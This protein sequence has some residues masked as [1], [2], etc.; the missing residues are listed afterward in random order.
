LVWSEDTNWVQIDELF[1]VI[2]WT[3]PTRFEWWDG[4]KYV[5][6]RLW[7]G[8]DKWGTPDI[9]R[10]TEDEFV[11]H[12]TELLPSYIRTLNHINALSSILKVHGIPYYF[13]NVFYEY[14]DLNEPNLQI[15]SFGK[16]EHQISFGSLFK[17]TPESFRKKSMFSY[18]RENNGKFLPR[19]HPDK[20]SHR[21]WA[22]FLAN[23]D[24]F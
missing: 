24:F 18:L 1:V 15:D 20:D 22:K 5:Q 7:T 2:G 13:F 12:Q 23:Q 16:K 9:T 4:E 6:E 19:N 11:L 10:T 17:S 3:T 8:Y 14:E 21:L